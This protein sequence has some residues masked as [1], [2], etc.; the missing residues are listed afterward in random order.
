MFTFPGAV[1]DLNRIFTDAHYG[2]RPVG[3][4]VRD[5]LLGIKPK[6]YDLCTDATPDE[7]MSLAR[8]AGVPVVPTGLQHG[9]V[10]FIIDHVA[11]EVTTLRIDTSCD[12]RHAEVAFTRDWRQDAE[13][14][15]LTMNA[16]M[17]D[18]EG[19]LYDWYGGREDIDARRVRFV[20]SPNARITEDYLRILRFIGSPGKF[21]RAGTAVT[22][23]SE[24]L[25]AVARHAGGLANISVE[26]IWTEVRRILACHRA[27]ELARIMNETGVSAV[28]GL[29][30]HNPEL[31]ERT[32]ANG[33]SAIAFLAASVR[34]EKEAADL[35]ERWK[36]S[37]DDRSY[38]TFLAG[39][40]NASSLTVL[41]DA[42]ADN[43]QRDRVVD[44]AK[45]TGLDVRHIEGFPMP[46]FPVRGS[47]LLELGMTSGPIFGKTLKKLRQ[48]W[49]ASRFTL[50]REALLSSLPSN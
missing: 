24:G 46:L 13:R 3:G 12:G 30:A 38:L 29:P 14:R 37:S 25:E 21:P 17:V 36:M 26:R 19:N 5:Q 28:I 49:M 44:L 40:R 11:Y 48:D 22:L 10:S 39:N 15:D 50:T 45:L 34:D 20:G 31:A 9:T 2:L 47:D 18:F 8:K 41:E 6:D 23:D 7:M 4:C 16:M 27:P 33:G 35:A 42:L 43:V 32:A 1:I